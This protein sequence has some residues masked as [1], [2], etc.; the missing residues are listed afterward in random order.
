M[1]RLLR[2][3]AVVVLFL[4]GSASMQGTLL[5]MPP[6]QRTVLSNQM[7]F[8]TAEERSLPF[9]TLQL[10]I[11]GGSRMDSAGEEGAAYLTA[12][13]LLMGTVKRGEKAMNE[14]L[15]FMG[16]RLSL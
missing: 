2:F 9:I 3:S 15:D 8:L 14:E 1:I 5:A 12:K 11:D 16:K 4:L 13:G 10:L 7:V 6:V